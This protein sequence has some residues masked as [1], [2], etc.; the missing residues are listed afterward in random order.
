MGVSCIL[1]LLWA[2]LIIDKFY[3]MFGVMIGLL[4]MVLIML[5][6]F[7]SKLNINKDGKDVY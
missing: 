5:I 3:F 4:V 7:F 1:V 2:G 6:I